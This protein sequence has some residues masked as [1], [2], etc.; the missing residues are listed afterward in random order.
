MVPININSEVVVYGYDREK[1]VDIISEY[2]NQTYISL[3]S[4]ITDTLRASY[5]LT[6]YEKIYILVIDSPNYYKNSLLINFEIY[7]E[8]GTQLNDL[9]SIENS[10]ITVSSSIK[11]PE[12]INY[13][14]GIEFNEL[15]YDIYNISDKFYTDNCTLTSDNGNDITLDDRIKYYYASNVSLFQAGCEYNSVDFENKRIICDC[16]INNNNLS[17]E[18]EEEKLEDNVNYLDY[19]LSLITYKIILCFNLF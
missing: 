3:D 9:N 5:N 12:I 13:N 19:F 2:S 14:K 18:N 4:S 15:G 7:L 8:N 10:K 17:N 16:Y 11:N 1:K 6:I